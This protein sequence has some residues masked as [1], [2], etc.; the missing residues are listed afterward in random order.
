MNYNARCIAIAAPLWAA[1][2][3]HP[4]GDVRVGLAGP[5]Y[6]LLLSLFMRPVLMVFGMVGAILLAHPAA[7]FINNTFMIAIGGSMSGDSISGLI[8]FLA[9]LLIYCIAMTTMLHGI[10]SLVHYIPD[11]APRWIGHAIGISGASDI[12]DER[13]SSS[14]FYCGMSTVQANVAQRE[15]QSR[16]RPKRTSGKGGDGGDSGGGKPNRTED[17]RQ[18]E[19]QG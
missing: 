18:R 2:H 13:Q 3:I 10:F 6:M 7:G 11:N 12:G 16:N 9:Y 14:V 17:Q 19:I 8:G 15:D 5:G 4:D 1:A